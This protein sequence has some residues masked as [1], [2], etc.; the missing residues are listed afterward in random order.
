MPA[1]GKLCAL[2]L[3]LSILFATTGTSLMAA[4][5]NTQGA[6]PSGPTRL[7]L[8]QIG[9]Q[10]GAVGAAVSLDVQTRLS[11]TEVSPGAHLIV[12][13]QISNPNPQAVSANIQMR[14]HRPDASVIQEQV[15][16]AQDI[17]S[18][19]AQSVTLDFAPA[20]DAPSGRYTIEVRVTCA[21]TNIVFFHNP[22]ASSFTVQVGTKPTGGLYWG[23][24]MK[25][26]PWDMNKLA[27]WE[28]SVGKSM[29]IVH[30]WTFWNQGGVLQKFQTALLDKIRAHGSIPMVSWPS[31]RMGAGKTQPDFRLSEIINGR[32]DDYIRQWATDAKNWGKPFLLRYGHEMNAPLYSWGEDTNG[33]KRGD[34][35]RAWRHIHDIFTQVGA[36]NASWVWCPNVDFP[37]SPWP[38]VESLYPGDSYVDWTCMDGYNWGNGSYNG[39]QTFDQIFSHTYGNILR[40]APNKPMMIG[41]TGSSTNG[42]KVNWIRDTIG[43][44]IPERFA[45][46]K[47]VVWYNW[48][49]DGQDWRIESTA[50][51]LNAFREKIASPLYLPNQFGDLSTSPIPAM[52]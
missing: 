14:V 39:W 52:R 41:E 11:G 24:A 32:Y 20:S 35:V 26:I 44:A 36:S 8:P 50:D 18:G 6:A 27:S 28:N 37:K 34:F 30:F 1:K 12:S 40:V 19:Q 17:A 29:S 31:E 7:L 10:A 13:S 2:L 25:D 45:A 42:D 33:N 15:W 43:A 21:K 46:L 48:Q 51:T 49:F 38:T 4:S 9:T 16:T 47:A 3:T 5:S 22:S 23:I